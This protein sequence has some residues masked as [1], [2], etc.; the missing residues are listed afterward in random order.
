[1]P[2]LMWESDDAYRERLAEMQNKLKSAANSI[3]GMFHS[4]D[5]WFFGRAKDGG[6]RIV[7]A[8]QCG[9]DRAVI[10]EE[11]SIDA[12]SWASIVAS[13][14]FCGETAETYKAALDFHSRKD[15]YA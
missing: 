13:V 15:S 14:S 2:K 3:S 12:D 8:L 4:K 9:L 5:G 11:I 7:K 10:E 6:V 1:M